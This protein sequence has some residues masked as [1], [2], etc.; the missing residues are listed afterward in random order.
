MIREGEGLTLSSFP[1]SFLANMYTRF[2]I[3]VSNQDDDDLDD[4]FADWLRDPRT[5]ESFNDYLSDSGDD[6]R[7]E[8]ILVIFDLTDISD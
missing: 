6:R 2:K 5:V 4:Q 1:L 3:L 8:D 7:A